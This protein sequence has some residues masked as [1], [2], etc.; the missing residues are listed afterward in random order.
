MHTI[1]KV[2]THI[3]IS[4]KFKDTKQNFRV[5]ITKKEG[6][7]YKITLHVFFVTLV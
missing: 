5:E 6:L 4:L 1:I 7:N 2:L 3:E